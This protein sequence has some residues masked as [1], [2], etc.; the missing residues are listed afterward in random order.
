MLLIDAWQGEVMQEHYFHVSVLFAHLV[1]CYIDY[2]DETD[3]IRSRTRRFGGEA[4]LSRQCEREKSGSNRSTA[5]WRAGPV[6]Y[7]SLAVR[8]ITELGRSVRKSWRRFVVGRTE[9]LVSAPYDLSFI[10]PSAVLLLVPHAVH[11]LWA[12]IIIMDL[13]TA[14]AIGGPHLFATYTLTFMEPNFRRRYPAIPPAPC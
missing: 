11:H 2:I 8:S 5:Q 10:V 6:R 3:F 7:S 13:V 4:S 12:S 1:H 9:W 14:A